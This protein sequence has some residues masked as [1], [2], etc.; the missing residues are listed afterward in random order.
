[1]TEQ[2]VTA[3]FLVTGLLHLLPVVGVVSPER[4]STLY[5]IPV[6]E[7][8]LEILMRHRAVLFG[9]LG[10]FLI[11]AGFNPNWQPAGFVAGFVS[12][13]SFLVLAHS[14]GNYNAAVR[15]IFLGDVVAL[16]CLVVA[17]MLYGFQT[18]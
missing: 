6:E 16:V 3:M 13:I 5:D 14:V 4:V 18:L 9:L 15:K 17:A 11:W 1:M 8:N 12:V 7:P 10:V 2:V